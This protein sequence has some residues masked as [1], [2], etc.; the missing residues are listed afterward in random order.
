MEPQFRSSFIPKKPVSSTPLR[1]QG[2]GPVGLLFL[3][4]LIAFVIVLALTAGVLLYQQFLV[5]SIERKGVLLEEARSAIEPALIE[6]LTRLDT[7]INTADALIERHIALSR[8][9]EFLE[10]NT[11]QDVQFTSFQ[12]ALLSSGEANMLLSG[13][14]KSFNAVALQSDIFGRSRLIS[15]PIFSGLNVTEKKDVAFNISAFVS[16]DLLSYRSI[17][18]SRLSE[19]LPELDALLES[20][21]EAVEEISN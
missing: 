21:E 20:E 16:P 15:N 19:P 9:F 11:I 4:T 14:A 12:F 13:I 2:G 10:N 17:A 18:E 1:K 7:R 3:L 6:E 5:R 8:L